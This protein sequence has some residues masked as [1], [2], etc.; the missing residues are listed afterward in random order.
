MLPV[1]TVRIRTVAGA[2]VSKGEGFFRKGGGWV[3]PELQ[4][5]TQEPCRHVPNRQLPEPGVEQPVLDSVA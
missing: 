3:I 1:Q 2:G 5:N 4:L